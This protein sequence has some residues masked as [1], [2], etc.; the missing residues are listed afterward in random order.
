M[1][2]WRAY[3]NCNDNALVLDLDHVLNI[4]IIGLKGEDFKAS[5]DDEH[6]SIIVSE[7]QVVASPAC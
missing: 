6:C 3:P 2:E 4:L 5:G 7:E 1:R